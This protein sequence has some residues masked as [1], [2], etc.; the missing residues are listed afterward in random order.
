MDY[1]VWLFTIQGK[2]ATATAVSAN[3]TFGTTTAT[4]DLSALRDSINNYTTTTGI[5]A[6]LSSDKTNIILVQNEGYDIKIG[7]VDF[8]NDTATTGAKRL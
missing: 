2:N 4:S 5:S 1:I 7:D 3:V 8:G 6:T